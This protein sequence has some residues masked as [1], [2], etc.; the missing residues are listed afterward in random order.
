LG[1][2]GDERQIKG[3]NDGKPVK[4]ASEL[5]KNLESRLLTPGQVK[6]FLN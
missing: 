6:D 4:S 2:F 1:V 5:Q 3:I